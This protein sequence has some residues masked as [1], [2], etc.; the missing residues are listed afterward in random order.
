MLGGF[1]WHGFLSWRRCV[2]WRGLKHIK[3]D[4]VDT[5]EMILDLLDFFCDV[6]KIWFHYSSVNARPTQIGCS[7]HGE[8][9]G[10]LPREWRS[11]TSWAAGGFNHAHIEWNWDVHLDGA[12]DKCIYKII[13]IQNILSSHHQGS[14]SVKPYVACCHL[15]S[16]IS[17]SWKDIRSRKA[18]L[19]K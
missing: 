4:I 16:V 2:A 15:L 14:S 17:C 12:G 19:S 8:I 7:K 10:L 13:Q 18:Q 6:C 1:S 3:H 11:N 9:P 5:N